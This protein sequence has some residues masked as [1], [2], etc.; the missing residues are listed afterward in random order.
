ML[1]SVYKED[2][3][4]Y[5]DLQYIFFESEFVK[6]IMNVANQRN[7]KELQYIFTFIEDM[8]V[9]GDEETQTMIKVAVIESLFCEK[10]EIIKEELKKYFG[11]LTMKSY[12]KSFE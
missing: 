9:N 3:D 10:D 12:E 7:K 1:R 8:L 4:Y 5:K 11:N 2:E 6:Y